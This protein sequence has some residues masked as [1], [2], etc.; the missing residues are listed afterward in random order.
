MHNTLNTEISLKD[1][2]LKALDNT[3]A[4]LIYKN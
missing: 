1:L 2:V 4:I 3:W